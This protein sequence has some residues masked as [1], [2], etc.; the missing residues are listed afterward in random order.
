[1]ANALF[2]LS[3]S[4]KRPMLSANLKASNSTKRKWEQAMGISFGFV[5]SRGDILC[6]VH[7]VNT[8]GLTKI[9]KRF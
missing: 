9:R 8:S 5:R 6:K 3:T 2:Q 4:I 1:M 7:T